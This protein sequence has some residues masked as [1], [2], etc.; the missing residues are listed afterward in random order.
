MELLL[1][2]LAARSWL[3]KSFCFSVRE[4]GI[5]MWYDTIISPNWPV[6]LYTGNPFPLKRT[7]VSFCVP[8]F[9]FS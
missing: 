3:N 8:G 9:T 6:C 5:L 7:F 2:Q 4:V 1:Y